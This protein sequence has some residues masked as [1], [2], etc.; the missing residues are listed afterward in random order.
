M[1]RRQKSLQFYILIPAIATVLIVVLLMSTLFSR[2]YVNIILQ[3]ENEVN[4]VGFEA[5]SQTVM[6]RINTS[7][8]EARNIMADERVV[9]YA[10]RSFASEKELIRARLSCRD[11][12]STE[13]ARHEGIC[14]LLFMRMDGSFFGVMP[15]GTFFRDDPA[16]NPLPEKMKKQI[17]DA[18]LGQT[19]WAGPLSASV[20]Y[21]YGNEETPRNIMIAAWKSRDVRYGQCCTLMMMDDKVFDDLFAVLQDGESTWRLFGEDRTEIWRTG[22]DETHP[23]PELLIRESNKGTILHD[24]NGHS[25]CTF[26]M[27]LDSPDWTLV[28]EVSMEE[29]EQ[30]VRHVRHSIWIGAVL[31][32][33]AALVGY[34]LWLKKFMRQFNSLENGIIR[35]GRGDL[36]SVE[37]EPFSIGEF[38]RMQEEITRTCGALT[39]Q[40]DT[41]RRMEREQAKQEQID[42]ELAMAREIQTNALPR[43]FPAFPGRTEFSLY[44]SM[45]PAKEVGGDFYDFFLIDDDHLALV[46]ADVSGKG[47]P[48][49]LFMMVS[50]TLIKTQM[51]SG[52]DPATALERVNAQ[53]CERNSSMM[54]VTVWLAVLQISTGKGLACNA[55]HEHPALQRAGGDFELIKYKHDRFIGV[56]KDSRYN[57]REFELHPGDCLFV[58][59]DGVPEATAG[60]MEMFGEERL[61]ELL[62]ACKGRGPEEILPKVKSDVDAFV[63]DAEQFDDLTMLCIRYNG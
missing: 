54:F 3:Q 8:T 6:P 1:K 47:I 34:Q 55:G 15:E 31:L 50:K 12:L 51:L 23:D 17:L 49:A 4:T 13:I 9:L 39:D 29:Y 53:L 10:G 20:L 58:Y 42:Q 52:C 36:E 56:R 24:E 16:E 27:T 35:M 21:G 38:E 61:T 57:N 59:T 25:F 45:T 14:G 43:E 44:A 40:M 26:S 7:I 11:Y 62:N 37:F 22:S 30:M 63:G 46:I 41:I 28:R 32:I 2:A 33:L 5:V 48:A 60:S 18:A 19:V